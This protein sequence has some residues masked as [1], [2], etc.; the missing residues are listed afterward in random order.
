MAL[1][2]TL[3]TAK[4]LWF[5]TCKFNC[6]GM[7]K[8]WTTRYAIGVKQDDPA[9]GL[10][11]A[12]STPPNVDDLIN[13]RLP[14]MASGVQLYSASISTSEK[15]NGS[16]MVV[17]VPQSGVVYNA[18]SPLEGTHTPNAGFLYRLE[19]SHAL[20]HSYQTVL[21]LRDGE[22]AGMDNSVASYS[23]DISAFSMPGANTGLT[24]AD[25]HKAW[26]KTLKDKTIFFRQVKGVYKIAPWTSINYMRVCNRSL[27]SPFGFA[28]TS[29][30]S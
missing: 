4:H 11:L 29:R 14:L 3:T 5:L 21:G 7:K 15:G 25:A 22:I 19:S 18:E 10:T 16:K 20:T 27:G 28:P 17:R 2:T 12:S 23:D 13:F 1:P 6:L 30:K 8:G 9:S 24:P 26:I